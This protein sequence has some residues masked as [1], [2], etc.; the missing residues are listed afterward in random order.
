MHRT[1][2]WKARYGTIKHPEAYN[3]KTLSPEVEKFIAKNEAWQERER[4]AW[5]PE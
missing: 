1:G 5:A 4:S 2:L 3:I